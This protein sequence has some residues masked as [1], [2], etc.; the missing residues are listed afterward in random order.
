MKENNQTSRFSVS[1]SNF[2]LALKALITAAQTPVTEPR[3]LAGIIKD[4]ELTY[5]LAWKTLKKFLEL[6]GHETSSAKDVISQAYQLQYISDQKI[7]L[8]IIQDR[9]LT[10][11]T[12]D[13]GFALEMVNRIKTQYVSEFESLFKILSRNQT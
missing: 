5:E 11:H 7:W 4:F 10:V 9:N 2:K 1:L 8:S 13:E 3:D 6:Q 12:Y